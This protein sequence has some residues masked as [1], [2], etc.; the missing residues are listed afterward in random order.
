MTKRIIFTLCIDIPEHLLVEPGYSRDAD[1]RAAENE[2]DHRVERA[3]ETKDKIDAHNL[4][5]SKSSNM[6][7]SVLGITSMSI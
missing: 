2:V 7:S 6:F 4:S 1:R 5:I 3:K